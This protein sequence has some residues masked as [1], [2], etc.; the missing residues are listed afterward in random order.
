MHWRFAASVWAFGLVSF[1]CSLNAQSVDSARASRSAHSL[2]GIV[3][4]RGRPLAGADVFDL[5]SLAGSVTDANGAFIVA[6]SDTLTARVRLIARRVGYKPADTT[7]ASLS[8]SVVI[9][10]EPLASLASITVLAGRYT[11]SAADRSTTLTPLEVMT[12][13]GG[14]DVNSAVKT[15]PGVQNVDEGTGVFVRGGDYTETRTFIDGAPTFTAYQFQEPTGSVAG[16]INPFLTESITLSSGGFGANWGNALS[17]IVDLRS[18]ARPQNTSVSVNATLLSVGTGATARLPHGLGLSATAGANNLA[19]LYGVNGSPRSFRPPPRGNTVSAQGIWEYSATGRL[20]LFALRQQSR[21]GVDVEDPAGTSTYRTHRV[22]DVIVASLRDTVGKWRHFADASTSGLSRGDSKGVY[23]SRSLLRSWQA[24]VES[25]YAWSPY[26]I[27]SAGAEAEHT[28]AR[29][30]SRFPFNGYN[31]LAGAPF[32]SASLDRGGTRDAVFVQLDTR[33]IASAEVIA[34]L[35]T[36]RSDFSTARTADPRVS[37]AWKPFDPLTITGSWG[38]YHQ[39]A[40][41]GLLDQPSPRDAFPALRAEMS[42]AG[43]Q[44]GDGARFARVEVWRKSYRDL[45]ALTRDYLAVGGLDGRASGADVFARAAGPIGTR[46]RLTWSSA[47]S[48]RTD[49]NTGLEARAPWD[50]TQSVTAVAERD[51]PNGWHLG[52]SERFATGRPFTDVISAVFDSTSRLFAPTYGAPNAARLPDYRR[53]DIAISRAMSLSG[54]GFLVVF[55][56]IQNPLNTVN[57]FGYT[58]TRDYTERV[59]VRSTVNRTLF[60]GANLVRSRTQ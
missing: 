19:L 46:L 45:V 42:I 4:G 59:P 29:F 55:G 13:P 17:G 21:M 23:D 34:G 30:N 43:L 7:I 44:L 24:R 33:P 28:G 9:S 14:G 51:W 50:V 6:L 40:D 32:L 15:L 27:A 2:R 31:P 35:R 20:K 58:W 22:T 3:L 10:L 52:V 49:P 39:L 18:Q 8:D 25:G 26:L 38:I 47:W 12:T 5:A 37:A 36:D 56:A 48:Q 41:P 1:G 11:S 16:T 60:I 57:L 54:G 53:A